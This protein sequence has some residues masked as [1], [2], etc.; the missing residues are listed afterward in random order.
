MKKLAFLISIPILI[1][2]CGK[3]EQSVEKLI[4]NGN[5]SEIR[6]KKSELS[7]EQSE[8]NA[9]ID[10]LDEAIHKLDKSKRL[11]LVTTHKIG[12]TLFKHYAEVQGDVTTNENIIIY[13]EY[14]GILSEVRVKEGQN[15]KKGQVLAKIDDGGL[16][17]ELAQLET[18]ANLAKTTYERQKRLWDQNIGSEIQYLETKANYEGL[19]SSVNR[20]KAQLEKT[21]VR[22]PFS[23][24]IDE[25]FTEE[26]EVVSPGQNRLFQLVNLSDMYIKA[27]V[28]ESY[29]NHISKG[30]EVL[31]DISSLNKDFEGKI[32]RVGNTI[33]PNNR[34]FTIEVAIPNEQ[35]KIK[36]NQIATLKL[37]DYTAENAMVVPENALLKNAKGESVVFVIEEE[38]GENE[39]KA[40]RVIVETGYS[41]KDMVEI[42]SGLE[43]Q[44]TLILEGAKNLRDG[45]KVKIR[46]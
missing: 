31:V 27:E 26:G 43:P 45:Q 5:L 23:G 3:N 38:T 11:D 39:A 46:N 17:S 35:G 28:P 30:T 2:S 1:V 32:R 6:N 22:A 42:T 19:K 18:N 10:R 20:L 12:D 15:I 37:N 9:K 16:S 25:V 7:K 34:S 13:P 4:E 44:Q 24:I 8:L 41:Y 14:S 29:L 33:N 40:R 21:V 36:P